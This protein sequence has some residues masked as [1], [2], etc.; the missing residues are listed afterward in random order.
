MQLSGLELAAILKAGNAMVNA[1]GKTTKEE[2]AVLFHELENFNVPAE[3]IPGLLVIADQ[4]EVPTM[5]KTLSDLDV[6]EK[7]YVCGYLAAIMASDGIDD[8]EV[9]L[10][11]LICTL[12]KFPKMVVGEALEFWGAH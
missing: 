7:K 3:Q 2:L 1:D 6:K 11:K 12:A 5:F 10:W 9:K 4:M 8:S